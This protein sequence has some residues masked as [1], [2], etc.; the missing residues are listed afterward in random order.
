M[1]HIA[2]VL[3]VILLE[4]ETTMQQVNIIKLHEKQVLCRE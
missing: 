1:V 3:A 2:N 4:A